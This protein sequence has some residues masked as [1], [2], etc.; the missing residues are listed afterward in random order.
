MKDIR[1]LFSSHCWHLLKTENWWAKEKGHDGFN[2]TFK[3]HK[4][5]L[6]CCRCHSKTIY[7]PEATSIDVDM[8]ERINT[9]TE[10]AGKRI[11]IW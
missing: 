4:N 7:I 5:F 11:F 3:V 8:K 1:C 9:T 6:E 10:D 2:K